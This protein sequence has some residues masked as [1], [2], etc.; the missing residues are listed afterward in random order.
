MPGQCREGEVM[1]TVLPVSSKGLRRE[2]PPAHRLGNSP[3]PPFLASSQEGTICLPERW[4]PLVIAFSIPK[5]G[6][7]LTRLVPL[8]EEPS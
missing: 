6:S 8:T 3:S 1:C 4:G 7:G 2:A 5:P